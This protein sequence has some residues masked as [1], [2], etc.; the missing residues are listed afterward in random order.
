MATLLNL[1]LPFFFT[2]SFEKLE[3]FGILYFGWWPLGT[4]HGD[5]KFGHFIEPHASFF[6]TN[7]FQKSDFFGVF[8]NFVFWLMAS[9]NSPRR[10]KIWPL[11]WTSRFLFLQISK[12]WSFLKFCILADG[13]GDQKF[14]H[15]VETHA[16][17]NSFQK[18]EFFRNFVFWLMASR[19]SP[20]R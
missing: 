6:F 3:F 12:I 4:G 9:R 15:F 8:R 5:Q 14:D 18:S 20:R 16:Y 13:H 17:S 10:S 7:S 1:V 11:L 2:T 19:N